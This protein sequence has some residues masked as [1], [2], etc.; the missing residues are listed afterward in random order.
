M[1]EIKTNMEKKLA[2]MKKVMSNV[3]RIVMSIQR[4]EMSELKKIYKNNRVVSFGLECLCLLF[5][6]EIN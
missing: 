2:H 3:E 5:N 1:S 4:S 6:E